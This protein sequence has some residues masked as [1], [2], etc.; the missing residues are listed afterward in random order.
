M[1]LDGPANLASERTVL[2]PLALDPKGGTSIDWYVPSRDAALLAV[3]LS[4]SGSERGDVHVYE[5]ATS[6]QVAEVVPGVNYGTAGGSVAWA[7]DASGFYYTRYPRPGERPAED[8][9][10]YTQV[11]FH[12]LGTPT[13][14][15]RYEIGKDF[16]RIAEIR[17]E[18]SLTT[19]HLLANVQNGDGGEFA[20]Y[21]RAPHGTWT[22]LTSFQDRV[23]H[24]VFG[25]DQSLYFLSRSGAPHGK[26]LR[27]ML[28]AS[29]QPRMADAQVVVPEDRDAVIAHNFGG[30][31]TI[32]PT[33]S[34]LRRAAAWYRAHDRSRACLRRQ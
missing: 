4:S 22:Q 20:Q 16:P 23:V 21:V 14:Q 10:F 12:R 15:D 13:E 33:A 32:L 34:P 8:R 5:T 25:L 2:D 31:D 27:L 29:S 7:P 26:I 6:K 18:A 19:G 3:S 9:D 30:A 17:L 24:A 28:G 11:Y 1:V